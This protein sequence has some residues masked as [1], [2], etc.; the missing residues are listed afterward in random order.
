MLFSTQSWGQQYPNVSQYT[1]NKF[2]LNPSAAG[3]D[4]YTT[5]SLLARKQWAGIP[6]SPFTYA[7]TL[8]SRILGDSYILDKL[9]IR[10]NAKKRT[11][12]GNTAYGLN[13]YGDNNGPLYRTGINATYAYH[14]NLGQQQV[15]FGLSLLMMQFTI[16]GDEILLDDSENGGFDPLLTGG[17]QSMLIA[18]ANFGLFLTS[19]DYYIGYSTVQLLNSSAQF[20]VRGTGE[21]KLN[22]QHNIMGGYRFYVNNHIDIDPSFLLKMPETLQPQFDIGAKCIIDK[23][24]WGGINYR[25]NSTI[26]VFAGYNYDKY[27]FGYAFEYDFNSIAAQSFATHEIMLI[28]MFGD[29][30]RRFKWLNSY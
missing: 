26:A 24:Y 13:L 1:L 9:P 19:R 22:R 17:K 12:S 7:L 14:L 30:A 18:D 25:T 27:Y 28:A 29:A 5:V 16:D 10:K 20:G 21:Y 2:V 3:V 6:G 15:S 8:D 4:G 11:R 23:V